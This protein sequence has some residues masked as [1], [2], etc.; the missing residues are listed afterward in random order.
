MP[1]PVS[2]SRKI[3][4]QFQKAVRHGTVK[5]VELDP[6]ASSGVMSFVGADENF[7]VRVDRTKGG[8]YWFS[9]RRVLFEENSVVLEVFCYASVRHC[10]RMFK[11][12]LDRMKAD[13]KGAASMK[14]ANYD[15]LEIETDAGI[16]ILDGL[17]QAYWPT[18][19]SLQWILKTK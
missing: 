12:L 6:I 9:D 3:R 16:C 18:L 2:I 19:H 11:D 15:R 5:N 1:I 14:A 13:L 17:G 4:I 8:M 10:H 7:I